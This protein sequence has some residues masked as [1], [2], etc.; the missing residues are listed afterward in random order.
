[1]HYPWLVP[2]HEAAALGY[3]V[4]VCDTTGRMLACANLE[5]HVIEVIPR[6]HGSGWWEFLDPAELP[7]VLAWFA[8]MDNREPITYQQLCRIDG[9]PR[10]ADITLVKAWAGTAWLCYGA[11][12]PHPLPVPQRR[13]VRRE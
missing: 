13:G 7:G 5:G 4:A 1:M 3:R 9:V 11:V 10:M 12:R 6:I 2:F 8:D